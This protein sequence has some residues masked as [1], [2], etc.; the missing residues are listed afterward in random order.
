MHLSLFGGFECRAADGAAL[1]FPTRKV[2]ALFAYL[3]VT[4]TQSHG[5]SKLAAL[6][7]G[8]HA[9]AEA[10]A[11]LRKALSRLRGCLPHEA[12]SCLAATSSHVAIRPDGLEID[13][14]RFERLV[15]DGTP[16]TLE[17]AVGLYRGPLLQDFEGAAPGST[18][19]WARSAAWTRCCNRRCSA[20]SSTTWSPARSIARFRSR[21]GCSR[22]IPCRRACTAA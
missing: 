17:G 19:G 14:L 15:A 16:E 20:C 11:N 4:A 7:W 21:C 10:R 3:L 12:R 22:A 5:R 8:D 9:E 18:I 2:Q 13:V 1:R 6:L